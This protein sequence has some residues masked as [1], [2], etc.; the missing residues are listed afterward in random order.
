MQSSHQGCGDIATP[1]ERKRE[2]REPNI[3][4]DKFVSDPNLDS[5]A[6]MATGHARNSNG[7]LCAGRRIAAH[8]RRSCD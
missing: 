1:G 5:D 4:V 6:L 3:K 2:I 7:R 8:D